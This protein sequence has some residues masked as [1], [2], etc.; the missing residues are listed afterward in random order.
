MNMFIFLSFNESKDQFKWNGNQEQLESFCE[1]SLGLGL[2]HDDGSSSTPTYQWTQRQKAI[3]CKFSSPF[4]GSLTWFPSKDQ[5]HSVLSD[6]LD[7]TG[8]HLDLSHD[9]DSGDDN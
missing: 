2:N 9:I 7:A 3:S 1:S 5:L 8:F 6:I 4:K